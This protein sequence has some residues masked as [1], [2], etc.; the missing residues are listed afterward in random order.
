MLLA[1]QGLGGDVLP[2]R[3][4]VVAVVADPDLKRAAGREIALNIDEGLGRHGVG[5]HG[6]GLDKL[7]GGD[8]LGEGQ[9]PHDGGVLG[10]GGLDG[11]GVLP[12]GQLEPLVA[13]QAQGVGLAEGDGVALD[14]HAVQRL[15]DVD[16]MAVGV[17][18]DVLI[19]R[20]RA[21]EAAE[22][23]IA[24][25]DDGRPVVD[26]RSGGA[27]GVCGLGAGCVVCLDAELDR[28][29]AVGHGHGVGAGRPLVDLRPCAGVHLFLEDVAR[30]VAVRV[31]GG[32]PCHG[33]IFAA[34]DLA[35]H[36]DGARRGGCLIVDDRV[37]AVR[38]GGVGDKEIGGKITSGAQ[39]VVA[40]AGVVPEQRATGVDEAGDVGRPGIGVAQPVIPRGIC[41]RVAVVVGVG[42]A[43]SRHG[44]DAAA[45]VA[46]DRQLAA[47]GMVAGEADLSA[48]QREDL[49]G[50]G[51]R[52]A[53][54]S[55][56]LADRDGGIEQGRT[57]VGRESVQEA[58]EAVVG[59]GPY[60]KQLTV[61]P[62]T[63]V[64]FQHMQKP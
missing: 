29:G 58:G 10:V 52:P 6:D 51:L 50:A 24:A 8:G 32:T 49:V 18:H 1:V 30:E 22:V 7:D 60:L 54:V 38:V 40:A 23:S 14:R 13:R 11:E 12:V 46:E 64:I 41:G 2:C 61:D 20:G 31:S 34:D 21:A 28:G 57:F 37:A 42:D 53:T 3:A 19:R 33:D 16:L 55:G 59:L 47:A 56:A 15:D 5:R 43:L 36:V 4:R 44:C 39:A 63:S 35:R 9:R 17:G 25:A 27:R 26:D 62:S 45:V 48:G